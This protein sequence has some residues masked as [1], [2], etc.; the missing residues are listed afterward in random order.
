MGVL[1][2]VEDIVLA[3]NEHRYEFGGV[4]AAV[5][6]LGDVA[7]AVGKEPL[8]DLLLIV[9]FADGNDGKTPE[10]A[11]AALRSL[12]ARGKTTAGWAVAH[13][14]AVAARLREGE[15]VYGYLSDGLRWAAADNLMNEACHCDEVDPDFHRPD[16]TKERYPFQ[17][18]GNEALGSVILLSLLDDEVSVDENGE[19]HPVLTLLPALPAAWPEGV[20]KGVRAR[21]VLK[22]DIAWENGKLVRYE[23]FGAPGQEVTL[24]YGGKT[25]VRKLGDTGRLAG[26]AGDFI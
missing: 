25:A 22:A 19:M 11:G 1:D 18:D 17:M 7:V 16:L 10:L 24:K 9:D 21:G 6:V 4:G 5:G 13:R 3:A 8:D 12:R 15:M 2:A 14:A 23:L 26:S 20:V